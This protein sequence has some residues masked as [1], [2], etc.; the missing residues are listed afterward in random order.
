MTEKTDSNPLTGTEEA[1]QFSLGALMRSLAMGFTQICPLGSQVK[2]LTGT[3]VTFEQA[4]AH[5][6]K[7]ADLSRDFGKL[8][9]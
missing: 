8:P 7:F 9:F 4:Q 2:D 5:G 6:F 3:P 1:G